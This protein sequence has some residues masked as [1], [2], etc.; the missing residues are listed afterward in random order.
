MLRL[1]EVLRALAAIERRTEW[2]VLKDF[3]AWPT[4]PRIYCGLEPDSG[5][6]LDYFKEEEI[7]ANDYR[8]T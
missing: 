8:T 5:M 1:S 4:K 2:E 7:D 6:K 3:L